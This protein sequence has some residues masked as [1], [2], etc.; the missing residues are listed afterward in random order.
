M[1]RKRLVNGK[2]VNVSDLPA[3][4]CTKRSALDVGTFLLSPGA[5]P[6]RSDALGCNP[7]FIADQ[8]AMDRALGL[9]VE[10]DPT[11]GEAILDT[12]AKRKEVALAAGLHDWNGSYSDP[13]PDQ[14]RLASQEANARLAAAGFESD[15]YDPAPDAAVGLREFAAMQQKTN[16]RMEES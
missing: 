8:V 16:K 13:D 5:W 4:D 7:E 1:S 3:P 14:A 15:T 9:D 2:W 6:M 10:Y 12:P 11:T